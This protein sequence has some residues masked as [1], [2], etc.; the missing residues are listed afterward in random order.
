MI[1]PD[2]EPPNKWL[3]DKMNPDKWPE[4][5]IK[6]FKG[7]DVEATAPAHFANSDFFQYEFELIARFSKGKEISLE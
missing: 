2:E 3:F 5:K 1:N 7:T 6:Q 4:E